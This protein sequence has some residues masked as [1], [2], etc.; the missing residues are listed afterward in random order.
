MKKAS[1]QHN[2]LI[3][4]IASPFLIGLYC[5]G[6]LMQ[7]W[8]SE[9]KISDTLL[10]LLVPI[11][12][13]YDIKSIIYTNGPGSHMATKLTFVTLKTIEIAKGIPCIGCS[14]FDCNDNGP[15]KAVGNLYFVKEK[16]TIITKK[17]DKVPNVSFALPKKLQD[18]KLDFYA[19]PLHV[20]PAV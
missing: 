5:D 13:S 2:I 15:I 7:E 18:I 4:P 9:G 12:D 16:E 17:F 20:L 3:I 8:S 14:G 11:L 1:Q 6:K 19:M 10:P